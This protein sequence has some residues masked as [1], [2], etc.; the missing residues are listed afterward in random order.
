MASHLRALLMG[1]AHVERSAILLGGAM[2]VGV[3]VAVVICVPLTWGEPDKGIPLAVGVLFTG[4]AE[5]GEGIGRRWRTMAWVTLWLMLSALAASLVSDYP[6]LTV[7]ASTVVALA[8]GIAGV[9]GPRAA[10]GGLLALVLFTICAGAPELP[11]VALETALLVGL[12]GVIITLVTVAPHLIRDPGGV[13]TA[14]EEVPPLWPRIRPMLQ[15]SDP[16]VRHGARLAVGIAVGTAMAQVS[17]YPHAYWL[18]MT[19]AWVTRPDHDGTVTKVAGRIVGTVVGLAIC[20]GLLIW[21]GVEGYTAAIV[22]AMAAGL[23]IAFVWAN[24]AVAVT[25]ITVMVVVV[26]AIDG[27]AV[28]VDLAVRMVT[29][30]IAAAMAVAG[31]YLWPVRRPSGG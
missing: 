9:A 14:L 23:T 1:T 10:L 16:F 19:I 21:L 6:V 12:G 17:G 11:E 5:A 15:W 20:G 13:R 22:C 18:P 2:R 26:F 3:V 31:S 7:I 27:D 28:R 30:L 4:I 8:A 24:Y 25:G 29:T